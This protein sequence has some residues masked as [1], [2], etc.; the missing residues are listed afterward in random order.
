MAKTIILNFKGYWID[1]AY[2]PPKAGIYLVYVGKYN[3]E[4]DKVTLR[5]LIYIGEAEDVRDRLSKHEKLSEWQKHVYEGERLLFSMAEVVNPDRER[6]EC[7]LI[8]YHKP[9]CNDDECVVTFPYEDTTVKSVGRCKFITTK[10][11]RFFLYPKFT[12]KKTPET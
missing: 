1:S 3:K 5:K 11:T 12:V 6:A 10:F 8:Y 2:V 7:A 9:P 4:K